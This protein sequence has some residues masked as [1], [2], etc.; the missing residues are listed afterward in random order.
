MEGTEMS[1][2]KEFTPLAQITAMQFDQDGSNL[3]RFVSFIGGTTE[4][5]DGERVAVMAD[6]E[7]VI[8]PGDYAF[9]KVT[10]EV[11][12]MYAEVFEEIFG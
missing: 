1:R 9:K 10:G 4:V 6:G 7:T 11:K 2:T 5:V 8:Y 12:K 3:T